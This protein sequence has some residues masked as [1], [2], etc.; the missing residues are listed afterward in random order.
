MIK[1][2]PKKVFKFSEK[3][4]LALAAEPPM[5]HEKCKECVVPL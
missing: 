4:I 2:Y 1:Y 3:N 5:V